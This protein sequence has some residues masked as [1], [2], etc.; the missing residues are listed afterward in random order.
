MSP[1]PSGELSSATRILRPVRERFSSSVTIAEMFAASLYVGITTVTGVDL[2]GSGRPAAP[3]V[4]S[5][6][7]RSLMLLPLWAHI[8]YCQFVRVNLFSAHSCRLAAPVHDRE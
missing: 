6:S 1:V 2:H 8:S 7:S 4:M 5:A 3:V